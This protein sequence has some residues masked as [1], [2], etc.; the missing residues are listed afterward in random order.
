M[1]SKPL[2]AKYKYNL[3]SDSETSK[4]IATSP[5]HNIVAILAT[6]TG[7]ALA[8]RIYDSANGV[9]EINQSILIAANT[10]ESTL[11][12]PCQP[13]PMNKGIYIAVEMGGAP[14]GGEV[15]ILYN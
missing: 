6:A 11:F 8:A 1:I 12:T 4:Q 3:D 14:F 9:G 2:E 13:V 10:G 7:A 5:G 15:L